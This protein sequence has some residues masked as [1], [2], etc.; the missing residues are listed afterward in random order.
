MLYPM[1]FVV[2]L[3]LFE[4]CNNMSWLLTHWNCENYYNILQQAPEKIPH[5]EDTDV[6]AR[7][8]FWCCRC[9]VS[10]VTV[11][12]TLPLIPLPTWKLYCDGF[13]GSFGSKASRSFVYW[14]SYEYS[15]GRVRLN[16]RRQPGGNRGVRLR[17]D[18]IGDSKRPTGTMMRLKASTTFVESNAD[19]STKSMWWAS[20][21]R[22][23]SRV[24]TCLDT[25]LATWNVRCSN[26]TL[27]WVGV[28]DRI[29]YQP[30]P[31]QR[32]HVHAP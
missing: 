1:L 11:A 27:Y 20:A 15:P 10:F 30:K 7:Y 19:A 14:F 12:P 22:A 8:A 9:K 18:G 3:S 23:A 24:E 5:W 21:N 13:A 32:S 28:P 4:G 31:T 2:I 16:T 6:C 26:S 17:L 25:K 29:C